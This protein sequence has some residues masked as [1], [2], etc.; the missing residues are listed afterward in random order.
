V[1]PVLEAFGRDWRIAELSHKPFPSGRLTHGVVDVLLQLRAHQGI[2]AADVA[3]V[4]AGVPP[5]VARLVG[6]PDVP[7][8]GANYARLC[9]P[10]VAATA[11]LRGRVDV[12]DFRGDALTAADAHELAGRIHVVVDGN[13]D[14][15]AI[16]P[17]IVDVE[18]QD[19]RHHTVTLDRV[20]GHPAHPL[21]RDQNL[22]KFRRC[23][24][25]GAE[26]LVDAHAA[27]VIELVD[28]LESLPDVRELIRLLVP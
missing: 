8:P 21:S 18:L 11:L 10:F 1:K 15:N 16:V 14:E 9:L 19:G 25:Y 22:D 3:R 20:I 2:T 27:R 26:R 17:Q 5:L 24:T 28:R 13:P 4:T 6:R 23:W 12:P 7:A